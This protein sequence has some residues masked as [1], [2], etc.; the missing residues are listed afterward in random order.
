MSVECGAFDT[1]RATAMDEAAVSDNE[2]D[3]NDLTMRK[4]AQPLLDAV[5]SQGPALPGPPLGPYPRA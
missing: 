3:L 5:T 1:R 2:A 4:E